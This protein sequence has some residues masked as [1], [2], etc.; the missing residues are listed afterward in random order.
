MGLD[1]LIGGATGYPDIPCG[2]GGYDSPTSLRDVLAEGRMIYF[3]E[4]KSPF[5]ATST[6]VKCELCLSP[7]NVCLTNLTKEKHTNK[8]QKITIPASQVMLHELGPEAL[9]RL[10]PKLCQSLL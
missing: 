9:I 7:R 10:S 8:S 4:M 5:L 1:S 6:N 3:V 2:V